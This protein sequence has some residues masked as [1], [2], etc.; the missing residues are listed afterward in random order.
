MGHLR[1]SCTIAAEDSL[2]P[3]SFRARRKLATEEMGQGLPSGLFAH[4][5]DRRR[6]KHSMLGCRSGRF[7][8]QYTEEAKLRRTPK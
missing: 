3:H 4:E 2:S 5:V 1:P 8:E 6:V 7:R